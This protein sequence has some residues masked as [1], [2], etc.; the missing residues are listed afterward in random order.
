MR[1]ACQCQGIVEDG[2]RAVAHRSTVQ[3]H[4]RLLLSRATAGLPVQWAAGLRNGGTSSGSELR[5]VVRT[6]GNG[7]GIIQIQLDFGTWTLLDLDL[8]AYGHSFALGVIGLDYV[9]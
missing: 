2:V 3:V 5:W 1:V 9:G 4:D 8:V 7:L 6:P